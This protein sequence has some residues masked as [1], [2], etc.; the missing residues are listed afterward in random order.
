[1]FVLLRACALV[2]CSAVPVAWHAC[3]SWRGVMVTALCLATEGSQAACT[4]VHRAGQGALSGAVCHTVV[5]AHVPGADVSTPA[6][7][8]S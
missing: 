2:L 1:M 4:A 5:T 7:A 3:S 8:L 6:A